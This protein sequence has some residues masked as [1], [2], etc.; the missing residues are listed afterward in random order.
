MIND[1]HWNKIIEA[2]YSGKLKPEEFDDDL[3]NFTAKPLLNAIKEG[4]GEGI[5]DDVNLVRFWTNDLK[6]Q[7]N[8]FEFATA[9]TYQQLKDL[10]DMKQGFKSL[11]EFRS[12]VLTR[13]INELYNQTYLQVEVNH[14]LASSQMSTKWLDIE[15]G[16]EAAPNLRYETVGDDRVRES[17]QSL[18][19]II[20]PINDVFWE[21]YYPPNGYN[22]RCDVTPTDSSANK[23]RPDKN[24]VKD[25]FKNNVGLS[26]EAF[27]GKHPYFKLI[28]S[29]G[30]NHYSGV[31][32][33][34]LELKEKTIYTNG[35]GKIAIHP[36]QNLEELENNL[37][38]TKKLA[39]EGFNVRLLIH[40][41]YAEVNPD[42]IVNRMITDFK[43]PTSKTGIQNRIKRANQQGCELV[44]LQVRGIDKDLVKRG[45]KDSFGTDGT[46]NSGIKKVWLIIDNVLIPFDRE[47]IVKG[48][49]NL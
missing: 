10:E 11:E 3:I 18:D 14:M 16:K 13:N 36:L 15:A 6:L 47:E 37:F 1:E 31:R 39:D 46:W 23:K 20:R 38:I 43:F 26:G 45:V 30:I 49:I 5:A 28:H 2:I 21:T 22:C 42:A 12:A 33:A 32:R 9:K 40:D 7:R 27:N 8:A 19:G 24:V 41:Q 29:D 17:H 25:L 48:N 44:V 34:M 35:K 4:R